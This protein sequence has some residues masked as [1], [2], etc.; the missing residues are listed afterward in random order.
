MSEHDDPK[1]FAINIPMINAELVV[2]A[3]VI[4]KGLLHRLE[5]E[6][7]EVMVQMESHPSMGNAD[8][9]NLMEQSM[10][11]VLQ[12]ILTEFFYVQDRI[13]EEN[14]PI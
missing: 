8:S 1:E 13:E 2:F 7:L 5:L 10:S 14:P 4:D 12:N 11:F 9:T 6:A 3:S